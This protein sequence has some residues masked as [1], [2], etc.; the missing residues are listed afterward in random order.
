MSMSHKIRWSA[1]FWTA[2]G[3]G[4]LTLAGCATAS[5]GTNG[6]YNYGG[7]TATSTTGSQTAVN[8][9]CASGATVC[10]KQ[11]QLSGQAATVLATTGGMTLYYFKS[12]TASSSACSGACSRTWP[13]LMASGSNVTG[14]GLPGTLATL[15]D[16]NGQQ[17]TYNGHPLYTYAGDRAQTDA[18]GQGIEGKWFAATPNLATLSSSSGSGSSGGYGGY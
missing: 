2:L 12:D 4:A 1:L 9:N 10:T 3:I 6:G 18:N 13:A 15:K 16:A 5:G 11:V 8:L 17:V 14:S 7:T